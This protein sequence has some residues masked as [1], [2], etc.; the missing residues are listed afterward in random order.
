MA[1]T[2]LINRK[3]I[4]EVQYLKLKTYSNDEEINYA[5][6]FLE[7]LTENENMLAKHFKRVVTGGKGSKPVAILFPKRIQYFIDVLLTVR[8]RCVP[9]SNEYLFADPKTIN[10]RISGYHTLK[11]LSSLSGVKNQSLFTSTRLRKQI[12]T[13]LQVMNVNETEIEQF[14]NFMGHTKK[15]H[16]EYYRLPHDIFQIAKVSK[17]RIAINKGKG[18][19]YKGK[20][21]DEI[22]LSDWD[23][24]DTEHNMSTR[25]D[26]DNFR[27]DLNTSDDPSSIRSSKMAETIEEGKE[28]DS[29]SSII[30]ESEDSSSGSGRKYI[31]C[32]MLFF[33]KSKKCVSDV[34][35]RVT[36]K[37]KAIQRKS[38]NSD[39]V[40]TEILP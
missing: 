29:D 32:F 30:C 36:A 12:A 38:W 37:K 40:Y 35:T 9:S 39:W 15:T 7:S 17:I 13:V 22:E 4:G 24:S 19:Q 26:E 25:S 28:D 33:A 16:E 34:P 1:L 3:R 18:E 6:E 20:S 31:E 8:S 27:N 21:L 2:L 23:D 10:R 5:E 14:A 11:K